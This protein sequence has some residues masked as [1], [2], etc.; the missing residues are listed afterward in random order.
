MKV[1]KNVC[2]YTK[3]A[4]RE[5]C[6]GD[7]R[8]SFLGYKMASF[9]MKSSIKFHFLKLKVGIKNKKNIQ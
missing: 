9:V 1:I 4:I 2:K 7:S 6:G 8:E 3:C 5:F